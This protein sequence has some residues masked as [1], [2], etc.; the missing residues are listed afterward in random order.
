MSPAAAE[1]VKH[2]VEAGAP[3]VAVGTIAS[4]VAGVL[5]TIAAFLSILWLIMQMIM[6]WS[7]FSCKFKKLF[8]KG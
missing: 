4:W 3:L 5:P 2:V 8:K 7:E 6:R 1:Q